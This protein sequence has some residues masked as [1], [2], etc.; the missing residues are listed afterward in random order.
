MNSKIFM[1]INYILF[2]LWLGMIVLSYIHPFFAIIFSL[3]HI[4]LMFYF[5]FIAVYLLITA[6]SKQKLL[7]IIFLLPIS[8]FIIFPILRDEFRL[9]TNIPNDKVIKEY[10]HSQHIGRVEILDTN[11]EIANYNSKSKNLE[12]KLKI[13]PEV[14][15]ND[16]SDLYNREDP[17]TSA[18][19]MMNVMYLNYIELPNQISQVTRVPNTIT[20]FGYWGDE[21]IMKAMFQKNKK[22]YRLIEPYPKVSL[23]GSKNE[24]LQLQYELLNKKSKIDL[25]VHNIPSTNFQFNLVK[26]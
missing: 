3:F 20:V 1:N 21:L 17:E 5:M 7:S 2:V 10:I 16:H 13:L 6:H 18:K 25:I 12:L 19:I 23:V 14:F 22:K 9:I 11:K 15:I 24:K 4:V 26:D 8:F